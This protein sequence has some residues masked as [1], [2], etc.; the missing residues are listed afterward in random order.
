MGARPCDWLEASSG[1]WGSLPGWMR[2]LLGGRRKPSRGPAAQTPAPCQLAWPR[3]LPALFGELSSLLIYGHS[4]A[5]FICLV[6]SSFPLKSWWLRKEGCL[7]WGWARKVDSLDHA[8]FTTKFPWPLETGSW[9]WVTSLAYRD[10]FFFLLRE[11]PQGSVCV[12]AHPSSL[13]WF[14]LVLV[15]SAPRPAL[16][17]VGSGILCLC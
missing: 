7:L 13:F 17:G 2:G 9:A 10:F 14:A 5:G 11:L 6:G 1:M 3:F 16:G 8:W 12:C 15:H 4:S